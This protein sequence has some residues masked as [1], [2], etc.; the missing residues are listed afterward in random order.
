[1]VSCER[2]WGVAR[3]RAWLNNTEQSEEY[4]QLILVNDCTPEQQAGEEATV[5]PECKTKTVHQ[6]TKRCIA[7][8]WTD[9]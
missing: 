9:E 5:C 4:R 6:H 8:G 3:G 7:C 1:M 2:C